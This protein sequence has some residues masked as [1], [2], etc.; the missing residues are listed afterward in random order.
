LRGRDAAGERA[1][2]LRVVCARRAH[3]VVGRVVAHVGRAGDGALAGIG[4]AAGQG[5]RAGGR[6]GA[7]RGPNQTLL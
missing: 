3:A 7:L 6:H 5:A 2:R 4:V 1:G